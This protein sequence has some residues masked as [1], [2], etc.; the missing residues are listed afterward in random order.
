MSSRNLHV[1]PSTEPP[2]A[3]NT[4][5][6]CPEMA[7]GKL[8]QLLQARRGG[9]LEPST[10]CTAPAAQHPTAPSSGEPSIQ[11]PQPLGETRVLAC[12]VLPSAGVF[13]NHIQ[14]P[15]VI[16]SVCL[17]QSPLPKYQQPWQRTTRPVSDGQARRQ[18]SGRPSAAP[19]F[20][21]APHAPPRSLLDKPSPPAAHHAI[22]HL[23]SALPYFQASCTFAERNP[24]IP[25]RGIVTSRFR[26]RQQLPDG[27]H[28]VRWGFWTGTVLPIL[29]T[30][31]KPF[32]MARTENSTFS[33]SRST[34]AN[35]PS[36]L[37]C[38]YLVNPTN[39][40]EHKSTS[41]RLSPSLLCNSHRS[42]HLALCSVTKYPLIGQPL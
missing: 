15:I 40:Q 3:A 14:E 21:A 7:T 4:S 37:L 19:A 34:N 42:S 25:K 38:I 24:A 22:S 5:S 17:C 39:S 23:L 26:R 11:T 2:K 1:S 6:K 41:Y 16:I 10:G 30:A 35:N 28:T 18:R 29:Q 27:Q 12:C 36:C 20:A 33:I 13:L 32:L 31:K 8:L 9:G